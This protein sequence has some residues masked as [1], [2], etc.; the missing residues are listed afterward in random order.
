MKVRVYPEGTIKIKEVIVTPYRG[1]IQINI[2][3]DRKYCR[4]DHHST[5]GP[6]SYR[7]ETVCFRPCY[8]R[9]K[10]T[11]VELTA[12]GKHEHHLMRWGWFQKVYHGW[13]AIYL[14]APMPNM[15]EQ[16]REIVY[17]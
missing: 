10:V 9:G 11:M 8:V 13:G 7:S 4:V 17:K 15:T 5:L 3:A 14:L 6:G 1:I 16:K 2:V 12:E